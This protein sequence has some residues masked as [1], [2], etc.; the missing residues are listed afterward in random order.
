MTAR[1]LRDPLVTPSVL[2]DM[3]C[4]ESTMTGSR[5]YRLD[6]VEH[7]RRIARRA[8]ADSSVPQPIR[9]HAAGF[10][11]GF[12]RDIER[13]PTGPAVRD[14]GATASTYLPGTP[15]SVTEPGT[16]AAT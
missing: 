10:T 13:R 3:V 6:L 14:L 12:H 9:R 11:G 8:V 16:S 7:V 4:T 2:V 5:P 15:A 1:D